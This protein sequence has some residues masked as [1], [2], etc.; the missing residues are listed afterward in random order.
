[1][2]KRFLLIIP[3]LLLPM[4]V[5]AISKSDRRSVLYDTVFFD[6]ADSEQQVGIVGPA[7]LSF[8]AN[9]AVGKQLA[10]QLNGWTGA[11]FDCLF[12]LW[13]RESSWSER[14][15]ND[16]EGNNDLNKNKRLDGGESISDTE[17]DAYGIPQALPGGKMAQ[18]GSDWRENPSTQI[19]WGLGYIANRYKTPCNALRMWDS[20]DPHWY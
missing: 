5:L 14:A 19:K 16:A 2:I 8:N 4:Q 12:E 17:K 1:M 18:S 15:I 13:K 7:N 3:I 9:V 6:S 20:R 11:E 10:E